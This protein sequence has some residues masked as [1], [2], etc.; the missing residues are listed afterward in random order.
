MP[1]R[2]A[3]SPSSRLPRTP[4]WPLDNAN[5]DSACAEQREV[6]A[7][8]PDV[9]WLDRDTALAG[10]PAVLRPGVQQLGELL[11]DHVCPVAAQAIPV[12]AVLDAIHADDDSSRLRGRQ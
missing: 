8:L 10:S 4:M 12:P 3:G 2:P 11:D 9:P 7:E 5:I 6:E 1:V